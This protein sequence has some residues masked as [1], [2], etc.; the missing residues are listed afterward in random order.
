MTHEDMTDLLKRILS[1]VLVAA[2]AATAAF[3]IGVSR[4][5][6]VNYSGMGS[7]NVTEE[8]KLD[9]ILEI[10]DQNYIGDVDK[11]AL[12]EAASAALVT[13]TGDKWSYYMTRDQYAQYQ[14]DSANEYEGIGVT[15][16]AEKRQGGFIVEA[17]DSQ[18]GAA[19]AGIQ[20]GDIITHVNGQSLADKVLSDVRTLI[21]GK[22]GT[23]VELTIMRDGQPR[24][25]VVTRGAIAVIVA[26]GKLLKNGIGLVTIRNFDERCSQETIAV[27]EK[28]TADGAKALIFDVRNNPGGYKHELVKLLDYLLPQGKIFTSESYDG[29]I[30]EDS[31]DAACLELP[32][33]VLVNKDSYSAAEFFAAALS[34]YDWAVTVGEH[35]TG[36]GYFQTT[37]ELDDG[38]AVH[39]SV[40]KYYTPKGVSLAEV[41]GIAPTVKS[42][43]DETQTKALL[44]G[45]LLP[46]NDP[47]VQ[48]AGTLLLEKLK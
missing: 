6:T 12:L 44:A 13:A 24:A 47:Q 3:L 33:A 27:I 15:V 5:P 41:K 28:L 43:L 1:Y 48:A 8:N 25:V 22:K 34:E 11:T 7:I 42:L 40:G 29:K 10:I 23:S 38:S 31:S 39:L 2:V 35:T 26:E 19:Q 37:I 18:G 32:M 30:T 45:E 14:Q 21:R 36:K 17:V 46:E 9:T 4:T 16:S 20:V